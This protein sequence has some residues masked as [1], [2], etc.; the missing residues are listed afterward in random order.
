[1]W[2]KCLT[3]NGAGEVECAQVPTDLLAFL[4]VLAGQPFVGLTDKDKG[5]INYLTNLAVK[6]MENIS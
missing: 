2:D 6:L 4:V 1:M 3:C 5:V